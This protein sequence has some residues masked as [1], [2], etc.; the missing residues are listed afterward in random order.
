MD[1]H[2]ITLKHIINMKWINRAVKYEAYSSFKGVSSDH[3]LR[4]VLIYQ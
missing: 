3:M 2:E 1:L 4:L